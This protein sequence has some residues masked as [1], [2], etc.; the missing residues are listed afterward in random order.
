V[1]LV[2]GRKAFAYSNTTLVTRAD[3]NRDGY[4]RVTVESPCPPVAEGDPDGG[5]GEPPPAPDCGEK[6]ARLGIELDFTRSSVALKADPSTSTSDLFTNC[7]IYGTY[8]SDLLTLNGQ[9]GGGAKVLKANLPLARMLD[10]KKRKNRDFTLR[11]QGELQDNYADAS[12]H[13]ELLYE[14]R[15]KRVR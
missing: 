5:G 11:V 13:T 3:V 15:F 8:F 4:E 1:N 14:I 7:P 6:E 10:R 12:T 9:P 2:A